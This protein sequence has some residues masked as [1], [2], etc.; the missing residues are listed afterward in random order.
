MLTYIWDSSG[1]DNG[2]LPDSTKSLPEPMLTYI[3]DTLLHSSPGN[4]YLKY[5]DINPQ[6]V[7]E[8]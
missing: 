6:V 7:F 3:N 5:Q 2:L 8:I 1:Y 4:I